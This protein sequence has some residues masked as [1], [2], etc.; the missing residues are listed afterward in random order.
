MNKNT[1]IAVLG[2]AVVVLLA[3]VAFLAGRT[4]GPTTKEKPDVEEVKP[5][6]SKPESDSVETP[7]SEKPDE[8]EQ[9]KPI[10]PPPP[11]PLPVSVE[12]EL[13][14]VKKGDVE[15]L[16]REDEPQDITSVF[17]AKAKGTYAAW[18]AAVDANIYYLLKTVAT[19]KVE[20]KEEPTPGRIRV[21]E[22]RTF[23]EAT[24]II[25]PA[26]VNPRI[27]LS[28]VPLDEIEATGLLL[29]G[30]VSVLGAPDM[31]LEISNTVRDF[32]D[33][34]DALDGLEGK[35]VVE[36]LRQFG[37]D[38]EKIITEPVEEYLNGLLEE[39]HS[40]VNAVQ[41]KSYRF[42]YWTDKE[43]EPLRVRY[44]NVDHS[45]IS[46]EEQNV[47]NY[48]NLF[49]DCH[50]LPDKD[51]RPGTP[52]NV[53]ASAVASMFGAVADG[54]CAGNVTVTRG[55][56]RPDGNWDLTISPS[57]ITLYDDHR[58]IGHVKLNGGKAVGDA[59]KAVLRELQLDGT[60]KLR[61]RDSETKLW[62]YDFITKIDGDCEFRST[63]LPRRED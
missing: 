55:N 62:F 47:L 11:P 3:V 29:G 32:R 21:E 56:D 22:I 4:D 14:P 44:E 46:L 54:T 27:D 39:V 63:L 53:E 8:P 59:R 41:G 42:V 5:D 18:G 30:L 38:V 25:K 16:P 60:G 57:T 23:H 40:H 15:R 35:P 9:E 50:V 20:S 36:L 31:G 45:P 24:E 7:P 61:K 43:G 33:Q 19:S 13:P 34:I 6:N 37:I 2:L 52:W 48:V 58:P 17:E 12:R 51:C 26:K 10:P 49:I 1:I 28:T